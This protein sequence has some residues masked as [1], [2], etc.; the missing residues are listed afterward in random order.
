[1]HHQCLKYKKL[2]IVSTNPNIFE[3][4]LIKIKYIMHNVSLLLISNYEQQ[5]ILI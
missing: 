2:Q 3:L 4:W 5:L 1:M